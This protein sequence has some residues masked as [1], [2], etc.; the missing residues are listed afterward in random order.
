MATWFRR[1]MM[2]LGFLYILLLGSLIASM[3]WF[4]MEETFK[5]IGMT[6]L[7]VSLLIIFF[8]AVTGIGAF[9]HWIGNRSTEKAKRRKIYPDEMMN[10]I[11]NQLNVEERNY[12]EGYL[13]A[14]GYESVEE[15]D[16]FVDEEDQDS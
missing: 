7:L 5:Q 10:R 2:M 16:F 9:F 14:Q 15:I 1:W 8:A 6:V 3:V 11:M 13:D 12:L 4:K